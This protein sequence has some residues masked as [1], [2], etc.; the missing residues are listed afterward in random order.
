MKAPKNQIRAKA[1]NAYITQA[2]RQEDLN[3]LRKSQSMA[4][5]IK[6][7]KPTQANHHENPFCVISKTVL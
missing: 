5:G 7:R 6:G 3:L 4:A 2:I 1:G